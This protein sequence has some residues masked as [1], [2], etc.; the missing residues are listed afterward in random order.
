MFL[1][2][3][4]IFYKINRKTRRM[5]LSSYNS[6]RDVKRTLEKIVKHSAI[7]SFYTGFSRILSTPSYRYNSR[8][9][10]VTYF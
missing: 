8:N 2:F 5:V 3:L 6:T 9:S 1:S 4:S 10:I 7:A